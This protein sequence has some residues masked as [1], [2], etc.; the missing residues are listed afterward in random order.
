MK[1]IPQPD[2]AEQLREMH[3]KGDHLSLIMQRAY[4]MA[5]MGRQE[6]RE[7]IFGDRR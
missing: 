3:R 2:L 1:L 6:V 7:I 4:T 5:K